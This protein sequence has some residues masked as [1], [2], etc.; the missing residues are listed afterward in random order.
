MLFLK[1]QFCLSHG[2]RNVNLSGQSI[3]TLSY[4]TYKARTSC[5]F[6]PINDCFALNDIFPISLR[7]N[8]TFLLVNGMIVSECQLLQCQIKSVFP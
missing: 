1:V 2:L 6:D 8:L 3:C 5:V 7:K 4:I